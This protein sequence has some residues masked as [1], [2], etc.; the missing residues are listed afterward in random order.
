MNVYQ[1]IHRYAENK[2]THLPLLAVKIGMY[3]IAF[4]YY[5]EGKDVNEETKVRV[6]NY[7]D[8]L[9]EEFFAR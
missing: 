1:A 6:T 7:I 5:T 3:A 8:M 2:P 9:L 4:K